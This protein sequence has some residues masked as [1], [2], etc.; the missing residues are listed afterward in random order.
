[1]ASSRDNA[2]V[3]NTTGGFAWIMPGP[4][5]QED[6]GRNAPHGET[7]GLALA[8]KVQRWD[9]G[10]RSKGKVGKTEELEASPPGPA[11]ILPGTLVEEELGQ[12]QNRW[13][14]DP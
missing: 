6:S 11:S 12:K 3:F 4:N 5:A 10:R 1:M 7:D 14:N 2:P 13:T 9:H 8:E